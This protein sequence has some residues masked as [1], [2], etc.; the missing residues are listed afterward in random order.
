MNDVIESI[1]AA[2]GDVERFKPEALPRELLERIVGAATGFRPLRFPSPP[3][4]VVIVVGDERD[5]LR[6]LI[7]EVAHKS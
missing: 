6:A 1:I 5:K 3:W 4:R 7:P 2:A